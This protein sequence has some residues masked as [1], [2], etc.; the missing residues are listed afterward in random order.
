MFRQNNM[1]N[2]IFHSLKY[3]MKIKNK[4]DNNFI[5]LLSMKTKFLHFERVSEISMLQKHLVHIDIIKII[6]QTRKKFLKKNFK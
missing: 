3:E 2:K 6:M 4:M 1:K 5:R